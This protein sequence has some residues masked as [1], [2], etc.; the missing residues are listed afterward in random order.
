MFSQGEDGIS[1]RRTWS[2]SQRGDGGAF[3]LKAENFNN[4]SESPWPLSF[5]FRNL[6]LFPFMYWQQHLEIRLLPHLQG[7]RVYSVAR[8]PELKSQSESSE[9]KEGHLG[10]QARAIGTE[11]FI[12]GIRQNQPTFQFPVSLICPRKKSNN[13]T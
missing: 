9:G 7:W 4:S 13:S 8:E 3:S 6:T 12:E 10:T 5:P 2:G 1:L 11:L